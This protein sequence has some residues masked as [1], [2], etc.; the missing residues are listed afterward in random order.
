MRSAGPGDEGRSKEHS[1]S[2]ALESGAP[3]ACRPE[4]LQRLPGYVNKSI[5]LP[6]TNGAIEST[7]SHANTLTPKTVRRWLACWAASI[8]LVAPAAFFW[9]WISAQREQSNRLAA[10][11]AEAPQIGPWVA[12]HGGWATFYPT[13][14]DKGKSYH[15]LVI[16]LPGL[17]R[18]DVGRRRRWIYEFDRLKKPM[19]TFQYRGNR[20]GV[21]RRARSFSPFKRGFPPMPLG[22]VSGNLFQRCSS[23]ITKSQL[24]ERPPSAIDARSKPS[25][26]VA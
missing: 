7:P 23:P 26:S 6:H 11:L 16:H 8:L 15:T 24:L 3:L 1:R 22:F 4:C 18:T 10:T 9:G 14:D 19:H 21:L 12:A 13:K 17:Q 20:A 25:L 5:R 2:E